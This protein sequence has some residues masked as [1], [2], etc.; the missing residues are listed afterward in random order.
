MTEAGCTVRKTPELAGEC[1]NASSVLSNN[2]FHTLCRP[3]QEITSSECVT[4]GS[5]QKTSCLPPRTVAA[6]NTSLCRKRNLLS[7]DANA[8]RFHV[9]SAIDS[10]VM[11]NGVTRVSWAVGG[12]GGPAVH[13]WLRVKI[14]SP[15]LNCLRLSGR[16]W[17]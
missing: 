5:L 13:A 2:L 11:S 12:G 8:N 7:S 10:G 16:V 6:H 4:A 1:N 9:C 3:G 14:S 17:L 15:G